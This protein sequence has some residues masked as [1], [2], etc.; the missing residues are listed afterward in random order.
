MNPQKK[1]S[2]N[3]FFQ[4]VSE[5]EDEIS[6]ILED[7][8]EA[9]YEKADHD[10]FVAWALLINKALDNNVERVDCHIYKSWSGTTEITISAYK[11]SL[12]CSYDSKEDLVHFQFN[13]IREDS[14]EE[15]SALYVEM[16]PLVENLVKTIKDK[17]QNGSV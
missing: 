4:T 8:I 13:N 1:M 7:G 14:G 11:Q 9:A 6:K 12:Y 15:Q 16:Q 5:D 2:L 17:K 3:E 10:L